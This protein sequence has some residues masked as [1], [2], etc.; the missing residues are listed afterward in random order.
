MKIYKLKS[1]ILVESA[2]KH[3]LFDKYV[4]DHFINDDQLY[5]KIKS[6]VQQKEPVENGLTL[7]QNGLQAPIGNQEIWASGVT[8]FNSKLA[9][10]E[11]SEAAGG[12]DFHARVYVAERPELFFKATP[13]RCVGSGQ[14]VRIRKDS[15]WN[16]PEPEL[17]LLLTSSGKIVGYTIGNDMSSRSIEGENPLYLP[18]AKTYDG[19][20]AI[21]PCIYV[22]EW[23]FPIDSEIHLLINRG[24][25]PVFE[26]K[27]SILQMKRSHE[28]LA[29]W[30]FR[31]LS[32]PQGCFLMTG[33]GIV[34][35]KDFTLEPGDEI[36]ISIDRIGTLTNW[37]S[38]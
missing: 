25:E 3:Y 2:E 13:H 34:P 24:G 28:E 12:G 14:K 15:T 1:G 5:Q 22:S 19:C 26:G 23:P 31:E 16:V 4:W 18:Q 10:Q 27:T 38:L 35:T 9:R 20:A 37:V 32:F 36:R 8:Y 7:L 29:G 6:L 21:G 33:T 17:T 11:E 30:L